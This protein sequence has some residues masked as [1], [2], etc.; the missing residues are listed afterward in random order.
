MYKEFYHAGKNLQIID[1]SGVKTKAQI[2]AEFNLDDTI[3]EIEIN[4]DECATMQ[5][6]IL[7][8]YNIKEHE[9]KLIDLKTEFSKCLTDGTRLSFIAERL[10][11]K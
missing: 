4:K 6:G 9:I 10:G 7:N 3:Q 11:L 2:I 8:K 5:N 1:V